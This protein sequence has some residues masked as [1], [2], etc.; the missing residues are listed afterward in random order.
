MCASTSMKKSM[1]IIA[2][3]G[4]DRMIMGKR[5]IRGTSM[6]KRMMMVYSDNAVINL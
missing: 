3:R 4:Y 6:M 2:R 1:K 5:N